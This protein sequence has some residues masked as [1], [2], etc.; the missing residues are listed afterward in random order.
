MLRASKEKALRDSASLR[1]SQETP[2]QADPPEL[3]NEEGVGLQGLS[4]TTQAKTALMGL[5]LM[6]AVFSGMMPSA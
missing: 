3:G 1:A 4:S 6:S 5:A 2:G